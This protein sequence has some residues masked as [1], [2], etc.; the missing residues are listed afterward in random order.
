MTTFSSAKKHLHKSN[1]A[2]LLRHNSFSQM[3]KVESGNL[4]FLSGQVALD[5]NGNL[6]GN[7]LASQLDHSL[8]NVHLALKAAG[9]SWQNLVHMRMYIVNLSP[10]HHFIVSWAL[11]KIYGSG[12]PP[13]NTLLGIT[14]LARKD[15]RVEVEVI[16]VAE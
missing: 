16:A 6:L 3:V 11:Q 13:S 12:D 10:E 8:Q 5:A 9:T 2:G 15:L 4:L 7:D 1:P 14:S